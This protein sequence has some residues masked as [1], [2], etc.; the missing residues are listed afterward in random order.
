MMFIEGFIF[1]YHES[2]H[3]LCSANTLYNALYH[4]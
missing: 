3:I 1:V 2:M 4:L